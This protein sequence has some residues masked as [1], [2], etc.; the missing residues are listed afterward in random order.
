MNGFEG[1]PFNNFLKE[2]VYELQVKTD[3][4]NEIIILNLDKIAPAYLNVIVPFLSPPNLAWPE[5]LKNLGNFGSLRRCKN[6]EQLDMIADLSNN[7]NEIFLTE[8]QQNGLT[9]EVKDHADILYQ[10][11]LNDI[12]KNMKHFSTIHLVFVRSLAEEYF[13]K[14]AFK[15]LENEEAKKRKYYRMDLMDPSQAPTRVTTMV[16]RSN[17]QNVKI[18]PSSAILNDMGFG[19]EVNYKGI[20]VFV[21]VPDLDKV[22]QD[23]AQLQR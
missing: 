12:L 9:I 2:M 11:G 18:Q 6:S 3:N 16:T 8:F 17:N 19:M 7:D 15:D 1:I 22:H 5:Y 20:V 4:C 13:T 10:K 21:V 14:T 23:S